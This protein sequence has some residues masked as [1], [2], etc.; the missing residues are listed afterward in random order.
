MN[1]EGEPDSTP[2]Q[3]GDREPVVYAVVRIAPGAASTGAVCICNC[4]GGAIPTCSCVG[5]RSSS[6]SYWY[7]N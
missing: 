1:E 6:G 3:D 4:V 5:H 2:L 7:P